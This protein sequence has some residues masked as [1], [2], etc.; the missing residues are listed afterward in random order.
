MSLVQAANL[1]Y[2]RMGLQRELKFA[3]ES[4]WT[5]QT[6]EDGLLETARNLRAE[7]W[8]TQK[9]AGIATPPSNDFSLYDHVLD[10][11]ATVGAIP[12]RFAHG[13]GPLMLHTYFAMARGS[14]HASAMEMTKWFDTNYHYVVPEFEAEMRYRLLSLKVVNQYL[15]AKALG[16]ETR[17][18]LLGP[19]SFVL[20]GKPTAASVTR[21]QVL[22][23]IVPLYQE[24]LA[25]LQAAG[26]D[27]VQIDEP[28]LC[29]DLDR[30]ARALFAAAYKGLSHDASPRLMLTT[31][32]GDLGDNLD[33]A[34]SLGT[35]G[36]H[37]DL[38]RAPHQL[39]PLLD[40]HPRDLHLSLG[41]VD[42]RN[43]WRTDLTNALSLLR[44]ALNVLGPDRIQVAP[45]CSLL[46]TPVDLSHEQK[47]DPVIRSWM[48]FAR[49]KLEEVSL[50][51]RAIENES[52][53]Q[54]KLDENAQAIA[55][56]R[57]STLIHKPEVKRRIA[58]VD[59]SMLQRINPYAVRREQQAAALAL[60][61]FPTTTIGSFPQTAEVRKTRAAFRNG[62]IDQ[63]AYDAFVEQETE[64]CIRFQEKLGID[65]LVHG[66]FERNDMVEYFGEQLDGFVFS[67]NGWVQSYGS[68]CVKPP[69]IYG[70]VSRPQAMT[71]RWSAYAQSLS[72]SPVKGMLTGPVTILQWSFV[73]D[74]QPRSL[75]CQQIALAIRDEAVD[76]ESAGINIIQIDEPA[77]REGLPL[78]HADWPEYL[79]WSVKAFRLASSGVA[80]KTQIH[81]HM[82]YSEFNDMIDSIVAMDADVI[83][84]ECSRSRMELLDAFRRVQYPNEI[85]P[86]VYDIHSPRVPEDGEMLALLTKALEVLTPRQLWINPDCGLKTRGWKEVEL[87]LTKMVE[88]AAVM[89]ASLNTP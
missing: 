60:P 19:V 4:F 78:R 63:S 20:L 40:K 49:Q 85:G 32:F 64:R 27:W 43:V 84:M 77:I 50:L 87:A 54:L 71:V 67:E 8:K 35:A 13:G 61:L 22:Q 68:R 47:L 12:Q 5:G 76:L 6:N 10:M 14:E 52:A 34:L 83:S 36:L 16:I 9:D 53:V 30:E 2:P 55:T 42:G 79:D 28:C 44:S 69:I 48:A 72:T 89:R 45:S 24:L 75:T 25:R 18:V 21:A 11:A 59:S 31:Y 80:D 66:E 29:L 23:A 73:R 51:A 82:C 41:L 15:E 88:T 57:S 65:V 46:H 86:G 81:T 33:L 62:R 39:A 26:A 7:H 3:L 58:A 38:V 70:D 74:D 1:G 17:P 37:V 56:R